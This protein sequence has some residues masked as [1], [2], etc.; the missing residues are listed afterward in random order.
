MNRIGA[1]EHLS[2]LVKLRQLSLQSNRLTSLAGVD[3]CASLEELYVS[4]N[5][6]ESLAGMDGTKLPQL[7]LLDV[8]GNRLRS[9]DGVQALSL[10][11]DV[12]ANANQLPELEAALDCLA[13]LPRLETLY[14]GG[15]PCSRAKPP[16]PEPLAAPTAGHGGSVSGLLSNVG[17]ADAQAVFAWKG[18]TGQLPAMV[19][20]HGRPAPPQ[21]AQPAVG[22]DGAMPMGSGAVRVRPVAEQVEVPAGGGAGGGYDSD[23]SDDSAASAEEVA[24]MQALE[25]V[26][27]VG[28]MKAIGAVGMRRSVLP[29][30]RERVLERLPKLR[31]LDDTPVRRR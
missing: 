27:N 29:G 13:A 21:D 16:P 22:T 9:L 15:N 28:I 26:A 1:I 19:D 20:R 7:I 25:E 14:L 4:E 31:Q 23:G 3:E 6:I 12:W 30:Y 18:A 5:R 8:A 17:S 2:P 10:L 24:S 11:E